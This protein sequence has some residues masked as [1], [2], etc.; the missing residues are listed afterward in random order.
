MKINLS[1]GSFKYAQKG[2]SRKS[3]EV[4]SL[5]SIEV[6]IEV[7]PNELIETVKELAHYAR[8]ELQAKLAPKA[9]TNSES[10]ERLANEAKRTEAS[11][12]E[13]SSLP[14]YPEQPLFGGKI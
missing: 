7:A 2:E 13:S 14:V 11:N 5:E 1:V 10:Y 6:G 3:K 9:D 8:V 12:L 4:V